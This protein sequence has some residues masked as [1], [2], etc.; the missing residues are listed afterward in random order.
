MV[1]ST[2]LPNLGK[3]CFVEMH[4]EGEAGVKAGSFGSGGGEVVDESE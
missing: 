1:V 3:V 2:V 4:R